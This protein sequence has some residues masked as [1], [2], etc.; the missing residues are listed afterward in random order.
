[1]WKQNPER[2]DAQLDPPP[3]DSTSPP[4]R[5]F[6]AMVTGADMQSCSSLVG[7]ATISLALIPRRCHGNR[8]IVCKEDRCRRS[9]PRPSHHCSL[10]KSNWLLWGVSLGCIHAVSHMK[11]LGFWGKLK[12]KRKFFS[13]INENR[14][15]F[16]DV[17]FLMSMSDVL[18]GCQHFYS[19]EVSLLL[20]IGFKIIRPITHALLYY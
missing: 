3:V 2:S 20:S 18:S 11:T 16:L 12:K 6:L 5:H 17:K 10:W 14:E 15:F 8:P 7:F 9:E 13:P 19:A 4:P 1:M